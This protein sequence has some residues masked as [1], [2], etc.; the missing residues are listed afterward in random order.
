MLFSEILTVLNQSDSAV[1]LTGHRHPDYDSA[2]ACLL[3]QQ[4]LKRHKCTNLPVW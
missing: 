1:V 2:A 3:M 4:F